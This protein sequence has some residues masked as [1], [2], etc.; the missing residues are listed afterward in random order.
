MASEVDI[1][2]L[3]LGH[4]G[5]NATIAS[6]RPPEGSPQAEHCARFYPIARDMLL[7]MAYWNFAMRR[8]K[9]AQVTNDWPEWRYAYAL[10]GDALNIVSLLPEDATDDYSTRFIPTDTPAYSHNYSPVIGAG[11]YAPQPYTIET[12]QDGTSILYSNMENAVL[13]YTV[14]V[15]DTTQFSPLFIMALSWYLASMLAGP[16]IK[17]AEGAAEAKRCAQMAAMYQQQAEMSDANQR[18]TTVEHIVPWTAGR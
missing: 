18:K 10:P 12:K 8:S 13:R 4:L 1:C 2:N 14:F 7:E 17:G 5:D 6:I 15:T 16:M 11:R 3:A 9:L